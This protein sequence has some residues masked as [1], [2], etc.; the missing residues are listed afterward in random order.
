[1]KRRRS[2]AALRSTRAAV[3]LLALLA[4]ATAAAPL[5]A[6]GSDSVVSRRAKNVRK[7]LL[8]P[9]GHEKVVLL[10]SKRKEY[11]YF[12]FT[13]RAPLTLEVVGPT[14]LSV[15]VRLLFDKTMKGTQDFSLRIEENGLLGSR[16]EV[17][18]HSFKAHKSAVARLKDEPALVPSK[19]ELLDIVVPAGNHSYHLA[20]GGGSAATAIVRIQIPKKDL[21]GGVKKRGGKP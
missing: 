17:S 9:G 8:E 3:A 20:L 2:E 19:A 6:A 4:L 1:M 21:G 15:M 12:K 18:T 7:V 10:V 11:K 16:K 14:T 13:P 5:P